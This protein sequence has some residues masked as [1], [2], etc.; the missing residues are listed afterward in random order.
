MTPLRQEQQ[1]ISADET[2]TLQ[3]SVLNNSKLKS[4]RFYRLLYNGFLRVGEELAHAKIP[5][6]T[7]YQRLVPKDSEPAK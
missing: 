1:K 6:E 4:F 5:H 2:E 7:K 3:T